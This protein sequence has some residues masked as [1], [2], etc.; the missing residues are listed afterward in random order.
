VRALKQ[1]NLREQAIEVIRASIVS[2]ELIPGEVYSATTLSARLGVSATPVREAMLDLAS[3]GLVEAVRNRGF[4]I[5]TVAD[6]DLDEISEL[7]KML[8]VPAVRLVV[9]RATDAELDAL[10]EN[11]S[12]IERAAARND[13][14]AFLRED[15]TFHLALLALSGNGRLVRL[16]SQLRDQTRL[17]GLR[18]V[19]ES[20]MLPESAAEHRTILD[21]LRTRDGRRAEM[22][23]R[24]H[25]DHT[26]GAWAG[27]T[28]S[29]RAAA[30]RRPSR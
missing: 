15:R 6:Q 4:R 12:S 20:G 1:T 19:A 16:V 27:L 2:G 13:L 3:D 7:R 26:R 5:L 11:V 10:E 25:L 23:V 18:H 22:L 17:M 29:P 30:P 9:K 21:A 24:E 28:E 8:E 14:P